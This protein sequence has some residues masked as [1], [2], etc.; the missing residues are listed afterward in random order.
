MK[1][2]ARLRTVPRAASESFASAAPSTRTSPPVGRSSPP[3][4]CSSVLLPDPDAPTIATRSPTATSRST[5]S[6][7]GTSS[8]P[9]RYVLRSPRQATTGTAAPETGAG[10]LIAQRVGWIHARGL[11]A[12]ID[13]RDERQHERDRRDRDHVPALQVRRQI[14]DV[15][16]ALVQELDVERALD[17]G[18]DGLD[19]L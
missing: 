15:V 17:R 12:R 7:T 1:P 5:P 3:S 16:D 11:E 19:V 14:A 18:H 8:G 6:S 13:R 10:L 2:S 4:R 9:L